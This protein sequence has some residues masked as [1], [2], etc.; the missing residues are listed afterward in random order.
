MYRLPRL[1]LVPSTVVSVFFQYGFEVESGTY[2]FRSHWIQNT[3]DTEW[4]GPYNV[5]L[6]PSS[7]QSSLPA[8]D[9]YTSSR[10]VSTVATDYLLLPVNDTVHHQ[11]TSVFDAAAGPTAVHATI[12]HQVDWD[13]SPPDPHTHRRTSP[14]RDPYAPH[15]RSCQN[16][17]IQPM[18]PRF[19]IGKDHEDHSPHRT[20]TW[21]LEFLLWSLPS[22]TSNNNNNE[23]NK[24]WPALQK[25]L[26]D[27][28]VV[29]PYCYQGQV[30]TDSGAYALNVSY[31]TLRQKNN[32]W[33][34]TQGCVKNLPCWPNE[35]NGGGH[36]HPP[37][38]APHGGGDGGDG[39]VIW[40]ALH[41]YGVYILLLALV[42]S[43]TFNCQLSYQ[44]QQQYYEENQD[45]EDG[46][47][48]RRRRRRVTR[49][50]M[51]PTVLEEGGGLNT[52]AAAAATGEDT[53]ASLQEPLLSP[54]PEDA[55][56]TIDETSSPMTTKEKKNEEAENR[57]PDAEGTTGSSLPT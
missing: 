40:K 21:Q 33:T 55:T 9:E 20:P 36:P 8:T 38:P 31:D 16:G 46:P 30:S 19:S 54:S 56:L 15:Y 29:G 37:H 42:I 32:T 7:S 35:D 1:L 39:N 18:L 51:T 24:W 23:A 17:N 3:S 49:R 12:A 6:P 11:D 10:Y 2:P 44:L 48:R 47:R 13:L 22:S 43:F 50:I 28:P 14:T 53:D 41:N 57:E 26:P 4:L 45:D 34:M 25:H 5:L 27:F 52:I